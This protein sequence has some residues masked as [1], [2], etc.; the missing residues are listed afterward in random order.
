MLEVAARLVL[1][2][3]LAGAS[4]AKLASPGSSRAAMATFGVAGRTAQ[5]LAW[6]LLIAAE[7]GLAAGVIAGSAT[8]AYLAAALI[9]TFAATMVAAILRGRAGA[10]CA[11]FGA[12]STVG[13]AAVARN[14]ALAAAFAALPAL[15]QRAL[16]TDE[17]LGLGLAVALLACA[18]LA[19]AV[20]ALAREVG[21]LRLRLGPATALEIAEEGPPLFSHTSL[22]SRFRLDPETGLALAVFVSQDC[23]VCRSLEPSIRVLAGDPRVAVESFEEE[24]ESAVWAELE[25]PGSP[26]AV[27]VDR[28][29]AVL[30]K[31]TFNNLAQ[32]E[33]VLATA[34]RRR[35]E[36][37][38][39]GAIGV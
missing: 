18:G 32:L 30:A 7:L 14:V 33:S 9:A 23:H 1:G 5:S 24:V 27:A 3:L 16:S 38:L 37:E 21:M 8:A 17:W 28:Q 4:I 35:A 6:G 15:P 25:I 31:G 34:E 19:V 12:R 36:R 20:L 11:C 10:P 2:G 39:A 26:F 29:G 22:I 13:W